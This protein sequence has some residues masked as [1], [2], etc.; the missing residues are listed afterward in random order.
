MKKVL[1]G[2]VMWLSPREEQELIDSRI[3]LLA[4]TQHKLRN[5][6]RRYRQDHP[7]TQLH[8]LKYSSQ[9]PPTASWSSWNTFAKEANYYK[10][11]AIE[12]LET[13]GAERLGVDGLRHEIQ[14]LLH[15]QTL[16]LFESFRSA[17]LVLNPSETIGTEEDSLHDPS[18]AGG[19]GALRLSQENEQRQHLH[20]LGYVENACKPILLKD[21]ATL[22][23]L[24]ELQYVPFR[25]RKRQ[26]ML[27]IMKLQK[28]ENYFTFDEDN[29]NDADGQSGGNYDKS[30]TVEQLLMLA[31][32]IVL[33]ND[34]GYS[35]I[36]L[37]STIPNAGRG[38]FVD[39]RADS[40][41]IVAF[42]P[43][44]VWPREYFLERDFKRKMLPHFQNDDNYELMFRY[45]DVL[46]DSR[47]QYIDPIQYQNNPWAVAH[48]VN[49]PPPETTYNCRP[50]MLNFT[51][52]ESQDEYYLKLLKK[53]VPN[54]YA[55]PPKFLGP[56]IVEG[57]VLMHGLVLIA[58]RDVCNEELFMNYRLNPKGEH[59]AWYT[60]CD[61]EENKKR[62]GLETSNQ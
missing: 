54:T 25:E 26:Y 21:F 29:S 1:T 55:R 2:E 51:L 57:H 58:T 24:H 5:E 41:S 49:H 52:D 61:E 45:D 42:F 9:S 56:R 62:W 43:G 31:K 7:Q 6:A 60:I 38:L 59:P 50:V 44:Q 20:K 4:L 27:Q 48:L 10:E 12:K 22:R 3:A 35:L 19:G 39:G 14:T 11:L 16:K 46:I 40:G 13:E 8:P 47:K 30:K 32:R 33:K 34:L 15:E 17:E 23:K 37:P 28:W 36:Q 18:R 53:Y